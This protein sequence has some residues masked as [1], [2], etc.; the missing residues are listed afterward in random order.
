MLVSF[1]EILVAVDV[2]EAD[3]VVVAEVVVVFVEL[4]VVARLVEPDIVLVS[5][6]TDVVVVDE[7]R[8]DVAESSRPRI[9]VVLAPTTF[10]T[11]RTRQRYASNHIRRHVESIVSSC[12]WKSPS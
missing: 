10:T 3:V 2:V 7:A 1:V 5:E 11:L 9:G 6:D 12:A 8:A 4:E